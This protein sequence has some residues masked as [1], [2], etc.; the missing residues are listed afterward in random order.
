MNN[1][2]KI[3][4]KLEVAENLLIMEHMKGNKEQAAYQ[5]GKVNAYK[6]VLDLQEP[7]DYYTELSNNYAN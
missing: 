1:L 2:Q 3:Q 6:E 4:H 7:E 5:A